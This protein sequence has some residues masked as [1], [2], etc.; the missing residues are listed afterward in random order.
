ML[1]NRWFNTWSSIRGSKIGI[2]SYSIH[3][4]A[5]SCTAGKSNLCF[6]PQY[7]KQF[8]FKWKWCFCEC[9]FF[10]VSFKVRIIYL[11]RVV[12]SARN[13]VILISL[14]PVMNSNPSSEE[15]S[16]KKLKG[17]IWKINS[18][19]YQRQLLHLSVSVINLT[20]ILVYSLWPSSRSR[21]GPRHFVILIKYSANRNPRTL[22]HIVC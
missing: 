12:E 16:G 9:F 7:R 17:S 18:H 19:L 21:S 14:H 20:C 5:V 1:C 8:V 4:Y 15:L 3:N 10:F 11:Y 22:Y 13:N 2:V 6:T